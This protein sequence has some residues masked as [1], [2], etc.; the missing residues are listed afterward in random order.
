MN[1]KMAENSLFS[2]LLRSS[3]WISAAVGLAFVLGARAI[4]P[5]KYFIVG[6]FGSLPFFVI[7]VISAWKQFKAPNPKKVAQCLEQAAELSWADFSTLFEAGLRADG[8]SVERVGGGA[9]FLT[10]DRTGR[11]AVVCARRWKGAKF[12][13]EPLRELEAVRQKRDTHDAIF[14]ALG[15]VTGKAA[16]FARSEG[17]RMLAG[18]DL[19]KIIEAGKRAGS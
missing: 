15:E 17:I 5:G 14:V 4:L 12:G 9:D 19:A 18:A 2:I 10:T 7:A 16:Q 6:A 11:T 8:Y 13:L 1:F 3:W